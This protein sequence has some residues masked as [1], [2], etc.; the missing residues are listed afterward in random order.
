MFERSPPE[1]SDD[2]PLWPLLRRESARSRLR[3]AAHA[4]ATV[5]DSPRPVS[6]P[7]TLNAV[8]LIRRVDPTKHRR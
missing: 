3:H 2:D 8:H 1:E 4:P 7:E 5:R 6:D